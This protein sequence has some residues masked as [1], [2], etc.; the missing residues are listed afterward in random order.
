MVEK[1]ATFDRAIAQVGAKLLQTYRN[2]KMLLFG[3]D[4]RIAD[5]WHIALER[6]L[7]AGNGER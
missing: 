5:A 2:G 4:G 6:A 7:V 3:S 1:T